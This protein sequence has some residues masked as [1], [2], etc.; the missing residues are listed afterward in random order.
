[1]VWQKE[2]A[3]EIRYSVKIRKWRVRGEDVGWIWVGEK[4]ISASLG[5]I[6]ER[7]GG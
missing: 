2:M 3:S 1:M 4:V 7:P 6:L 5:W